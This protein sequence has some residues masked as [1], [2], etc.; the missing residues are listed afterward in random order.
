M[1][2]TL[3]LN[4][5]CLF[6]GFDL[7]FTVSG[8]FW[9][10]NSHKH[11]SKFLKQ[12]TLEGFGRKVSDHV[13]RGTP[14]DRDFVLLDSISDKEITNIYVLRAFAARSFTVFLKENRALVVLKQDI[15]VDRVSLRFHK[16]A[17]PAN[18]RH[19][20]IGSNYFGFSTLSPNNVGRTSSLHHYYLAFVV[21]T[22]Y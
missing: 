13:T 1:S 11:V 4:T 18:G 12:S 21:L 3:S 22:H 6:V 19:E 10:D 15:I 20:V 17:S 8:S 2:A 16:V 9:R 7:S 14:N 5:D